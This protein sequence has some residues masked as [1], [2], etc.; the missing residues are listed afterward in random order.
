[1]INEH[2]FAVPFR[3][4]G[5]DAATRP[6]IKLIRT[7]IVICNNFLKKGVKKIGG[8]VL[9]GLLKC[10]ISKIINKPNNLALEQFK[11]ERNKI[12][13]LRVVDLTTK[14]AILQI[15]TFKRPFTC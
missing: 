2:K 9:Y 14:K 1:M 6:H 8:S 15:K 5:I 11:S 3:Q 7:L 4:F 10:Y 12:N 13:K